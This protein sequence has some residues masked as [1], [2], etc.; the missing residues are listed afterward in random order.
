MLYILENSYIICA[1]KFAWFEFLTVKALNDLN[2]ERMM[3]VKPL[4]VALFGLLPSYGMSS[5]L[6][7][8]L[9]FKNCV[10][11][12]LANNPNMSVSQAQ[13]AQAKH[14]LAAVKLSRLPQVVAS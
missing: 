8:T 14:A 7:E 2:E 3:R 13:I 6:A 11:A 10:E 12:T 9:D 1:T 4:V 5:A